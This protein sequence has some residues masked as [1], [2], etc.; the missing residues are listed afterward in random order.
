LSRAS[1]QLAVDPATLIAGPDSGDALPP[2]KPPRPRRSFGSILTAV[3]FFALHAA[4]LCAFFFEFTWTG[5][6]LGV[7][8]YLIRGFGLTAGFHRYFAHR[9][10]KTSRFFQFCLAW[11]GAMALQRGAM[12][13]ASHHRIHH[14]HSD[15][16]D[17]PHSP[18]VGTIWWS[19][20]GWV[21]SNRF[22][23][24]HWE[25]MPDF[26]KYPELRW[27][28]KFDLVPGVLAG[29]FCLAVGG[30]SGLFWG[31]FF[32]TVC[33]Y[34][35]TFLVNSICHLVGKRR[36]QT[37][38][39]SRN[40]WFVAIVAMGEGWH[41]NHHHYPSA[42]RQGF[43]WWE[44]DLSYCILKVLSWVGIVWDLRQPTP[45]ALAAK[46]IEADVAVASETAA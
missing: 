15:E 38:D 30:W 21:L 29:L 8:L 16:E 35:A 18:I 34:H 25:L 11:F 42:A 7:S 31:F 13:W 2:A 19:H 26:K 40:N 46:R 43:Y 28:E 10:Y 24:V 41:N 45:R 33:L 27:L 36:F 4:A 32:S 5:L 17:D 1:A 9:A 14:K 22:N 39:Y 20:V 23:D 12:W 37:K 6:V 3:A 44:F